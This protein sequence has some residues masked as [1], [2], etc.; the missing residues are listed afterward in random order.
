MSVADYQ[1]EVYTMSVADYRNEVSVRSEPKA[2]FLVNVCLV[3]HCIIVYFVRRVPHD[4]IKRLWRH[5][6]QSVRLSTW[7]NSAPTPLIFVKFD[8]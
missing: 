6:S 7:I 8:I 5:V 3:M 2:C 4:R 1:N